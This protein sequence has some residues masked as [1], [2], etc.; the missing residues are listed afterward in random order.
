M[1]IGV[2]GVTSRGQVCKDEE[3]AGQPPKDLEMRGLRARDVPMLLLMAPSRLPSRQASG[4]C[5]PNPREGV[6]NRC[7]FSISLS[8][9]FI[10]S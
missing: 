2:L 4:S 3:I 7:S 8:L 10:R 6:G 1:L 9:V 5:T